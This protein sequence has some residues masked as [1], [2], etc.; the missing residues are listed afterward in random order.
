MKSKDYVSECLTSGL[1]EFDEIRDAFSMSDVKQAS[2]LGSGYGGDNDVSLAR[3][4]ISKYPDLDMPYYWL[5]H[6][7]LLNG[8]FKEARSILEE[9][10]ANCKRKRKLCYEY[11]CLELENKQLLNAVKWWIRN[12]VFQLNSKTL[13]G[14]GSF[15]YLAYISQYCGLL[16]E[17]EVLFKITDTI[18]SIRLNSSG[19]NKIHEL[20]QNTE[21]S[22]IKNVIR[23]LLN[24]YQK[25]IKRHKD[26]SF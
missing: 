19:Q 14:Y 22:K 7:Y 1:E 10:I 8:D 26:R 6:Y 17:A 2:F 24:K 16:R 23:I 21:T 5:S 12:A 4:L 13:D 9:G 18:R 11:G 15:M 3:Q 20:A 25:D